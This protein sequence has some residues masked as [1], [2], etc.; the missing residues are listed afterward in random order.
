MGDQ[1]PLNYLHLQLMRSLFWL[2]EEG[3]KTRPVLF[4]GLAPTLHYSGKPEEG[5]G[6][7]AQSGCPWSSSEQG[8]EPRA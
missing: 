4:S 5:K 1:P 2:F 7:S 3:G 6:H 8:G